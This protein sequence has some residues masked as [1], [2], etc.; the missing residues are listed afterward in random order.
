MDSDVRPIFVIGSLNS[1]ATLLTW[2]LGQHPNILP[3]AENG[4]LA[5]LTRDLWAAYEL[6]NARDPFTELPSRGWTSEQFLE[7]FAHAVAKLMLEQTG[8]G[9]GQ[10][11][12]DEARSKRDFPGVEREDQLP[13]RWIDGSFESSFHVVGLR[14]LFP[15]AQFIHVV[16][17]VQSVAK[18]L[19]RD[20]F[21]ER[22]SR[23]ES[24]S[25]QLAYEH[26]LATVRAC[27]DA[28]RA[29]GSDIVLRIRR[30][31]LLREPEIV[32][33]HC[34]DFVGEAF[35]ADCLR[36]L[37]QEGRILQERRGQ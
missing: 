23:E 1:G 35:C 7:P 25:E 36:P 17:D 19:T 16:R 33:R 12:P 22:W 31:D 21:E 2:C 15:E 4:W 5:Q 24:F 28:E 13:K 37:R 3:V 34:L 29:L 18:A 8:A 10:K 27:I 26:W 6:A 9:R 30:E 11:E 32:I 20:G 14:K